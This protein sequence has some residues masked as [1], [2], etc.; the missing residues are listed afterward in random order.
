MLAGSS[1]GSDVD[2][3]AEVSHFQIRLGSL[4]VILL[5]EDV[6]TLSVDLDGTSLAASSVYQMKTLANTF[7]DKLG[8]FSVSAM[9]GTQAFLEAREIFLDAVQ[10]NHIRYFTFY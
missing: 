8:L 9:G 1:G 6:L 5:H 4:A 2:P 10:L 3:S 7:F